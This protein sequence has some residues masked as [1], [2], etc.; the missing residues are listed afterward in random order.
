M[1]TQCS[2]YASF[3]TDQITENV[4]CPQ[5]FPR[6]FTGTDELSVPVRKT[7]GEEGAP[8][9]AYTE[10]GRKS[11][12]HNPSAANCSLLMI[13]SNGMIPCCR[14]ACANDPA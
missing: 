12:R 10:S 2:S 7:T 8:A 3:Q 1:S 11:E 5:F 4:I 9:T 14:R 6:G 13:R